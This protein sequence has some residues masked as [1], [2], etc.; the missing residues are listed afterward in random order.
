MA[1]ELKTVLHVG[2]GPQSLRH[3][4]PGFHDGSWREVRFDIDPRHRPDILGTI[5]DMANVPD[6]S[7][8]A[9]FSS[10]NLEHVF[11]HEVASVLSEFR[12]VL[13]PDGFAVTVCPDLQVLGEALAQGRLVDTFYMSKLG[14]IS[15]LDILYGHGASIEKG[16]HYMAH[17]TGFTLQSLHAAFVAAG[18]GDVAAGRRRGDLWT[19]AYRARQTRARLETDR[20]I[21][22]PKRLMPPQPKAAAVA[23][24]PAS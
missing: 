8:D 23:P 11:A 4:P 12:R 22:L 16:Q 3:L 5:V 24:A 19:L 13:K 10:H 9:L 2:C 14:P 18:F 17:K 1:T 6:G 15:V 7:M 20:D 21:F